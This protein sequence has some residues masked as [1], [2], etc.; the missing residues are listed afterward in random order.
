MKVLFLGADNLSCHGVSYL[1]GMHFDKESVKLLAP[2]NAAHELYRHQYD[3]VI[4]DYESAEKNLSDVAHAL[5]DITIPVLILATRKHN[6]ECLHKQFPF[7]QGIVDRDSNADFFIKAIHIIVAGGYCYSWEVFSQRSYP[8][9]NLNDEAYK[10][11][12]LTAREREILDMYLAGE[13][14]KSIS[15]R[16]SR[17]E[18][19][20]SAHKSNILKKLG[21]KRWQLGIH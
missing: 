14:N 20:I 9:S 18:K 12:G 3:I 13:T 21:M 6:P 1:L 15:V 16:L 19:T 2:E 4:V 8:S 17:S 7:L 11:A 5:N 10:N